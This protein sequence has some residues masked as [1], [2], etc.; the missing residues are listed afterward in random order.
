MNIEIP[1]AFSFYF[2]SLI[3]IGYYFSKKV[4]SSSA[5][6][7]GDRSTNFF[8]SAIALHASDMSHWLFLGLPIMFYSSGLIRVWEIIG[9][10]LFM[11]LNWHFVAPKIRVETEKFK[12]VTLFSYFEKKFH[13]TS[14]TIRILTAIISV[15]FFVFYISSGLVALGRLFE[16]A[17]GLPYKIGIFLGLAITIFYTLIGGFVAVAWCDFF[18]GLF[19]LVTIILVPSVALYSVGG[20]SAI[21]QAASQ[22]GISL[23]IIP[24]SKQ[25]GQVLWLM[26]VWGPGYFGQPHLISFFMG[27][28]D[29]KKI[30]YSKLTGFIWQVLTL[31]ASAMIGL[32]GL[33]YFQNGSETIYIQLTKILFSPFVAGIMLCA[34][35]AATLSTLD[36][37]ILTSGSAIAQDIYKKNSQKRRLL[38]KH[39]FYIEA[40]FVFG[41]DYSAYSRI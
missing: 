4:K 15:V 17:F 10:I 23:N 31:S 41:C 26:L 30:R 34:I 6:I 19:A 29:P 11:F 27:I 16:D 35:I 25:I 20:W 32:V 18:Q 38:K 14:G 12:A 39:S 24:T 5:F 13:D 1:L 37:Y 22:R 8:V 21:S 9:L 40:V 2:L 3:A 28:K 36:S 33:V 7:L